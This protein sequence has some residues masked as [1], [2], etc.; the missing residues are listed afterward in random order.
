MNCGPQEI[1]ATVGKVSQSNVLLLQNEIPAFTSLNIAARC[2]RLGTK[3]I[4]D[5]APASEEHVG[6]LDVCDFVTP[7]EIEVSTLSSIEVTNVA[8]AMKACAEIASK[9]KALPVIKMGE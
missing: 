5:P 9:G 2:N 1:E 4:W 8:S 3:V 6:L 7:N